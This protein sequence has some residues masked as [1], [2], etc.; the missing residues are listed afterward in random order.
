LIEWP[1]ALQWVATLTTKVGVLEGRENDA[2]EAPKFAGAESHPGQ[3]P[4]ECPCIAAKAA[5]KIGP[6]RG[7]TTLAR[8]WVT[9]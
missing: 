6:D 8:E 9:V 5:T 4:E 2:P 1:K 7:I 3:T